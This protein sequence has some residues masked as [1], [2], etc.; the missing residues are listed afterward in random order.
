MDRNED[1][2]V[3]LTPSEHRRFVDL[4]DLYASLA[5][6]LDLIEHVSDDGGLKVLQ[7]PTT[8]AIFDEVARLKELD[9]P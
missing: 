6:K 5:R 8:Q 9:H 1:G 4:L 7:T 2:T 3:L